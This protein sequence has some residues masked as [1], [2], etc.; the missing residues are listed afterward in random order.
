MASPGLGAAHVEL[1]RPAP[2]SVLG[3]GEPEE[4]AAPANP[5]RL[6][7]LIDE[8]LDFIWRSL[9]RL[10]VPATDVDDCTQQVCWVLARKLDTIEEG[11]ER[12]FVFSTA[13]RVASDARRSRTR[14][15]EVFEEP[16]EIVDTR[17]TPE[18]VAQQRRDRAL[19]DEVLDAMPLELRTVFVLFELEELPTAEIAAALDLPTGTV[20]SRLRRAREEFR[21]IAARLKARGESRGGVR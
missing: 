9:R 16:A 2:P 1:P 5:A 8:H 12:P 3:R 7:R 13:L 18:Q 15:R 10:G 19:L 6:R 11:C 17:P 20:A 21:S 4:P 14:R